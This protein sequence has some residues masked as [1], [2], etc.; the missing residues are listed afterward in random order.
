MPDPNQPPPPPRALRAF[1]ENTARPARP[2][3]TPLTPRQE[4]AF[5]R[6]AVL[7]QIADV[8]HPESRYDYR[9]YWKDIASK[10]RDET[11]LYEDGLHFPDT[12]KQHGHP[13]FSQ[14]SKYSRGAW[15]G[16]L[17]VGETYLPQ[18]PLIPSHKTR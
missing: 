8:D 3:V 13:T 18:P 16:G 5:R 4:V 11:Q 7:N 9:G 10:G 1:V 14:E 15:D 17:W 6:W 2:E 12:Y